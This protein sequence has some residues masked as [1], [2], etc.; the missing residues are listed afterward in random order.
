MSGPEK[1]WVE[2]ETACGMQDEPDEINAPF[3]ECYTRTDP[4]TVARAAL[5]AAATPKV[6]ALIWAN[7][8]DLQKSMNAIRALADD[9]ETLAQIAKAAEGRG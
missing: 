2:P 7:Y 1:I 4:H 6:I 8:G 9:P 3:F 5:E